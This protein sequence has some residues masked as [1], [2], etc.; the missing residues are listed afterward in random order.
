MPRRKRHPVVTLFL[1]IDLMFAW[2]VIFSS[3]L[4]VEL[5]SWSIDD[6]LPVI[7]AGGAI[8][9]DAIAWQSVRWALLLRAGGAFILAMLIAKVSL[10]PGSVIGW[11]ALGQQVLLAPVCLLAGWLRR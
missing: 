11:V 1:V 6:W 4:L 10:G 3:A 7:L 9:V 5:L 8:F 2:G